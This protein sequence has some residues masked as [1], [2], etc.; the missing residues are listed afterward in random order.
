MHR[1]GEAIVSMI[2]SVLFFS[3][4]AGSDYKERLSEVNNTDEPYV[5]SSVFPSKSVMRQVKKWNR[6]F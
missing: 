6:Q 3:G 2:I 5:L 1:V 4:K